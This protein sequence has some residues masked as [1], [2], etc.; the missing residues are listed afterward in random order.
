MGELSL[1][2]PLT[3]D[4]A[5]GSKYS[6]HPL[7]DPPSLLSSEFWPPAVGSLKP[8]KRLNSLTTLNNFLQY[9]KIKRED[10]KKN[11]KSGECL[12]SNL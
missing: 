2:S 10:G 4:S 12:I 11:D 7:P 1:G 9:E 5:M 8:P 3:G 6:L